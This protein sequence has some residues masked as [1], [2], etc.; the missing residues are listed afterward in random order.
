MNNY[1]MT[2]R[3]WHLTWSLLVSLLGGL[4]CGLVGAQGASDTP[5]IYTCTDAQGRKLTSDRP[6]KECLDR[7]QKI[8]N[9]SVLSAQERAEQEARLKVE[10]EERAR[11]DE[12]KRRDRALLIRYPTAEVHQKER[13]EALA[14]VTRVKQSAAARVTQLQL[15]QVKL[16]D[17]MAFYKKDPGKAPLKLRRQVDELNQALAAQERF[18]V[19][20][21]G[22]TKRI[23]ARFDEEFKRLT[24]LWRLASGKVS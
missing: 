9:P 10:Q 5:Q 6:I 23:N 17:E 24:P 4:T 8:L 20:Q 13:A 22:E 1:R 3:P 11:Q 15:D 12:E 21:D 7:E 19:D 18:M 16:A 2:A 14:H